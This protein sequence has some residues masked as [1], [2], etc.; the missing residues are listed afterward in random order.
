MRI[1]GTERRAFT[2]LEVMAAL[3]ITSIALTV[4][5]VER[6]VSVR[7]TARTN[8]RRVALQLAEEKIHEIVLGLETGGS[9]TFDDRPGFRWTSEEGAESAEVEGAGTVF[10]RTISVTVFFPLQT[11]E[12]KVT[13]VCTVRGSPNG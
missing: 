5:L 13:L 4:L 9:G 8:D 10:L 7:R 3:A 1:R 6:N 11:A 2:L 12:D